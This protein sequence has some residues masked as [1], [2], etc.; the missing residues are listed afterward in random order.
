V[1][2][3]IFTAFVDQFVVVLWSHLKDFSHPED[4]GSTNLQN[5]GKFNHNTV[6]KLEVIWT[7]HLFISDITATRFDCEEPAVYSTLNYV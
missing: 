2:L 3:Y 5:F 6:H 7:V 1:C 4:G